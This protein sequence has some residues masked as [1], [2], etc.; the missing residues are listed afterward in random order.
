MHLDLSIAEISFVIIS[1]VF[2]FVKKK[3]HYFWE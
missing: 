2:L 1:N 3:I